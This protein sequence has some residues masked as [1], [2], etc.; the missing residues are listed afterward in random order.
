MTITTS[1]GYTNVFESGLKV[2]V[3]HYHTTPY[4]YG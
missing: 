1:L 4:T 2:S 3:A